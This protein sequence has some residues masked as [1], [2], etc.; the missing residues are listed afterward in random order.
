MP[1]ANTE[2]A[3]PTP[4]AIPSPEPAHAEISVKPGAVLVAVIDPLPKEVFETETLPR[5]QK[6]FSRCRTCEVVNITPY[7]KDGRFEA[8]RLAKSLELIPKSDSI[9]LITWNRRA[10]PEDTPIIK[11]AEK[12]IQSGA[13]IVA[14]A[15]RAPDGHPTV[16]I[17]S[18]LWGQIPNIMLVGELERSE[19][20]APGSFFGPEMVTALTTPAEPLGSTP[21]AV[22][23]AARLAPQLKQRKASEW[24]NYLREKRRTLRRLW[25]SLED[26][27]GRN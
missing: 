11:T 1:S 23:F 3:S 13:A 26:L 6:S 21:A 22:A 16:R 27:F 9:L 17:G 25:P 4:Q 15:G 12:L 14:A 20:L 2:S 18:T 8:E 10:G 7:D 5:I 24:L 19:K